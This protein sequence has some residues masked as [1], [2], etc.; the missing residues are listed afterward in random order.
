MPATAQLRSAN[1]VLNWYNDQD[2][3]AWK[4]YRFT[5]ADKNCTDQY[6]GINKEDGLE[7]LQTALSYIAPDDYENYVIAVFN[8]KDKDKKAPAVNKVFVVNERPAGMAVMAGYG[9]I[10]PQQQQINTQILNEIRALREDRI[11][12]IDEDE[13]EAGDD[14]IVAGDPVERNIKTILAVA[15]SPIVIGLLTK[16]MP[17]I[18][19]YIPPVPSEPV[20]AVAGTVSAEDLQKTIET[21]FG[22]GVTPEDLQKLASLPKAQIGMLLGMLRKM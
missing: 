4:I 19:Q 5:V 2:Q 22:K 21:L 9:G 17:D 8:S 7:R 1:A 15:N 12:E 18:A 13:D 16:F 11:S 14:S 20:Q 6:N 10:S 3:S